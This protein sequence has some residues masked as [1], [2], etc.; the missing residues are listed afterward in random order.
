MNFESKIAYNSDCR[1]VLYAT[2]GSESLI[3]KELNVAEKYV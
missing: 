1:Q 3:Q 2:F